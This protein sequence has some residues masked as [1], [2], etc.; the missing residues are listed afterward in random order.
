M[1]DTAKEATS[2]TT[3]TTTPTLTYDHIKFHIGMWLVNF[4]YNHT[5][6]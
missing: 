2:S 1:E 5:L 6:F 3:D 4:T